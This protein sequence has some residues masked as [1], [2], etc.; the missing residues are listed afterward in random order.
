[1]LRRSAAAAGAYPEAVAQVH[2]DFAALHS[3]LPGIYDPTGPHELLFAFFAAMTGLGE[4]WGREHRHSV[5]F[6]E[7]ARG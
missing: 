7:L 1:M 5:Q 3:V 2:A 6:L 4:Q